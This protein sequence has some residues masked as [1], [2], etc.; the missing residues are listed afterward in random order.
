[1]DLATFDNLTQRRIKRL[2]DIEEEKLKAI[3]AEQK[4][5]SQEQD[6]RAAREKQQ[7]KIRKM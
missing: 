4:R 2:I 6:A 3:Q 5:I 1:M 7:H